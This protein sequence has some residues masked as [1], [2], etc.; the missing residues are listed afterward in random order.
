[1]KDN[2]KSNRNRLSLINKSLKHSWATLCSSSFIFIL[3][4][5]YIS[6]ICLWLWFLGI[7][8]R[9]L[10]SFEFL[11]SFVWWSVSW[12]KKIRD[13][14]DCLTDPRLRFH[15]CSLGHWRHVLIIDFLSL[16]ISGFLLIRN[17]NRLLT[18]HNSLEIRNA[19]WNRIRHVT[20]RP[21]IVKQRQETPLRAGSQWSIAYGLTAR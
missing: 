8:Y 10:I 17:Q 21:P 12:W 14:S 4:F 9:F 18:A 16:E 1:M 3:I 15:R 19:S 6:L 20:V 13:V 7:A 11:S 5:Y 2:D